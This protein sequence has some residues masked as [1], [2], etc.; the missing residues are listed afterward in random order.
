VRRSSTQRNTKEHDMGITRKAN[1]EQAAA[2]NG[3]AGRG[4]V[5][6]QGSLDRLFEPFEDLLVQAVAAE[7]AER[8]LDLGCGTGATTLAIAQQLGADGDVVGLDISDP[9]IALARGR[10]DQAGSRARFIAAD[11]QTHAFEPASFD[12]I[13][14]RFGIMFFDDNVRAF[15]N[16]R[17]AAAEGA[18]LHGI[19]WRGPADNPFMTA[20][21]RAA[22]PLLPALPPRDPHA[23]GQFAFANPDR[24]RSILKESGWN[25]I[26]IEP[27]DVPCALPKNELEAYVSKLGPVGRFLQDVDGSTR[28]RIVEAVRAAFCSFVHGDEVRFSSACWTVRAR[29]SRAEPR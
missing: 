23:P 8:V 20:A 26:D 1:E 29:A 18:A 5:Q 14:S 6:A 22:A 2:W 19:A 27:L 7:G 11:A 3:A 21:E 13:V 12:M 17:R 15:T 28:K 4:W 25:A 9:M 24:V 10:A 16:L